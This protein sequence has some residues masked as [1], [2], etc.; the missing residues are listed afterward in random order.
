M[1]ISKNTLKPSRMK[2]FSS[3]K[4]HALQGYKVF[5]MPYFYPVLFYGFFIIS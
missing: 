5:I 4:M 3:I 1:T 2:R